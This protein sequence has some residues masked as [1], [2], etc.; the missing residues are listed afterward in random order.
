MN[1]EQSEETPSLEH[2]KTWPDGALRGWGTVSKTPKTPESFDL[3]IGETEISG[4]SAALLDSQATPVNSGASMRK[5]GLAPL[6]WPP[7]GWRKELG[8]FF[9]SCLFAISIETVSLDAVCLNYR[10]VWGARTGRE[11]VG[12]GWM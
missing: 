12:R 3:M 9:S 6:A 1:A 10:Q 4:I 2:R 7:G 11:V 5:R 8:V